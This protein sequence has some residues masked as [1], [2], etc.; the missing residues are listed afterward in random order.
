[1]KS[2]LCKSSIC[3][4]PLSIKRGQTAANSQVEPHSRVAGIFGIHIIAFFV[5]DH[6]R[7]SARRGSAERGPTG[8]IAGISGIWLMISTN[9]RWSSRRIAMK[10]LGIKGKLKAM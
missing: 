6:F 8:M 10:S 3:L 9:G 5:G 1:M 4:R 7:A 2:R